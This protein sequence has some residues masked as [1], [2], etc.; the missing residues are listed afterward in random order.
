MDAG[1]SVNSDYD[2]GTRTVLP[3]LRA[4]GVRKLDLVVA[5]HA[6]TDHIEGISGCCAVC[7]L[8]SCGW[9]TSKPMIRC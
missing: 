1:G 2:V 8:E 4:L 7:L 3:A 5:T 6:D 9:A